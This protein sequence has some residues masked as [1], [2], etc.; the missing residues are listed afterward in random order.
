MGVNE[1]SRVA[2]GVVVS[3]NTGARFGASIVI[4]TG[5]GV[6]LA[7]KEGSRVIV[8]RIMGAASGPVKKTG[9]QATSKTT[10]VNT[11][12]SGVRGGMGKVYQIRKWLALSGRRG[13][14]APHLLMLE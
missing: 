8:G 11:G 3:V 13:K 12:R 10:R 7:V 9:W 6:R 4:R 2:V 14:P 5:A 1:G